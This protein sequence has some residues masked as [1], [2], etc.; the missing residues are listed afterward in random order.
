MQTMQNPWNLTPRQIEVM[1][2]LCE[3][4]E[5]K[6]AAR[7]LGLGPSTVR[8]HMAQ[9]K[10]RMGG[11]NRTQALVLFDRW[12]RPNVRHKRETPAGDSDER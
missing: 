9:A 7:V 1:R 10:P 5:D 2:A 8:G 6:V 11:V 12:D 3:H 4:G